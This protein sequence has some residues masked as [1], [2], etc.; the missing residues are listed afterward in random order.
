MNQA[1][2][3]IGGGVIGLSI[4][5]EL[6]G[7]GNQV[8]LYDS[9]PVGRGT[10]WAAAGILPPANL[11]TATDPIDKLRGISHQQFPVWANE[12]QRSTGIDVG[13][14]RCGGW[15]L[16]DTPGE[17]AA[18]LGMADYW[19][20]LNIDCQSVPLT[21]LARQ[22]RVLTEW[23]NLNPNASAWW[24]PDEYQIRPPRYL[25][26][27]AQACRQRGVELHENCPVDD[28]EFASNFAEVYVG[29]QRIGCDSLVIC[30]GAWSG[31]IAAS[32][33]L[34]ASLVPVRG[35]IL[36]L[37]TPQPLV[38]GVVNIGNRYI[39]CR[40]DGHTLVGS[41]EE[42]VGFQPGTTEPVL[43][44]LYRF[45]VAKIPALASAKRISEW[46]GLRPMTF[47]GF[48][49]IGRVPKTDRVYV[50]A[51][52]YRSGLHL[53][54]GTAICMADLISGIRP[55]VDLDAFAVAKQQHERAN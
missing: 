15:Y 52:H 32:L 7:R 13:L 39:V 38:R 53:S 18:M 49:M 20:D 40:D 50:A 25:Q 29:G 2:T 22:E 35:Q 43:E 5:W 11:R 4:A 33:G 37:K 48:P 23:T 14:R 19:S 46:S 9:G 27:L 10:S 51:G 31:R 42:E 34:E 24:T 47:D 26:A 17:C 36:L 28:L 12:L 3:I 8:A 45:A 41:C 55:P 1:T 44:S 54:L 16:A 30:A 21:K 6:A